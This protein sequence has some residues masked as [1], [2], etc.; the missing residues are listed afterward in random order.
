MKMQNSGQAA[1]E[2]VTCGIQ[3]TAMSTL[4][5][6]G[7]SP[8]FRRCCWSCSTAVPSPNAY[9]PCSV[10]TGPR[11]PILHRRQVPL[12]LTR[13]LDG[14]GWLA[15]GQEAISSFPVQLFPSALGALYAWF[16]LSTVSEQTM[17]IIYFIFFNTL[18]YGRR[19]VA[20]DTLCYVFLLKIAAPA[21]GRVSVL[22]SLASEVY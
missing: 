1:G 14:H 13:R 19:F 2:I 12:E 16:R 5:Q 15:S 8:P 9:L 6:T 3:A 21:A 17:P 18:C 11:G 10:F 7:A 22:V 4:L 20:S